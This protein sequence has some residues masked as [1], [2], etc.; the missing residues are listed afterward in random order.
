MVSE[1]DA[2]TRVQPVQPDA[3]D[4]KARADGPP[5]TIRQKI[6]L[7]LEEGEMTARDLSRSLGIREREVYE[8][9][10]HIGRTLAARGNRLVVPPFACLDCGYVFRDRGR[11]TRPGRC[12]RCKGT[13]LQTPTY[14]LS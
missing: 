8:H 10:A 3:P 9:L 12:P 14:R 1:K 2:G 7:L 5:Q 13:H 11:Y 4:E 6:I